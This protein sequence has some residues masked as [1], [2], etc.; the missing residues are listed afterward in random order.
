MD[1]LQKALINRI[2]RQI[3][4][5]MSYPKKMLIKPLRTTL[6]D[7]WIGRQS[8]NSSSNYNKATGK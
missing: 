2:E 8:I 6:K 4:I 3:S 5:R 1:R 7:I